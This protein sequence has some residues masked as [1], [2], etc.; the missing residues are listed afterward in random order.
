MWGTRGRGGI[1]GLTAKDRERDAKL[2]RQEGEAARVKWKAERVNHGIHGTH[3]RKVAERARRTEPDEGIQPQ[4]D[5][6]NA[7]GRA[8]GPP[9]RLKAEL[10]TTS[11]GAGEQAR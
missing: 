9:H 3:G 11:S 7:D 8:M 5:G 2:E 10:R 6:M 4:M 1:W